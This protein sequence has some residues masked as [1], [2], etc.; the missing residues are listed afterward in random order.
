M[1]DSGKV[2]VSAKLSYSDDEVEY[3]K[4]LYWV[5]LYAL[6]KMFIASPSPL[7]FSWDIYLPPGKKHSE[8]D[9]LESILR[10]NFTF[11]TGNVFKPF[12]FDVE[13]IDKSLQLDGPV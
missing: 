3:D 6:V 11:H 2:D 4:P 7:K 12:Y 5:E 13:M 9:V 8:R 1:T 10:Y